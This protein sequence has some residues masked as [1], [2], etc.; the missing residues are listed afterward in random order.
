MK[1]LTITIA[2]VAVSFVA[3]NAAA[4]LWADAPVGQCPRDSE[5]HR[6]ATGI[7]AGGRY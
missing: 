2:I 4:Q 7:E 6:G 1:T 5:Q 3:T